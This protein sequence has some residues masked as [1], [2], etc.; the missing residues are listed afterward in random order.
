MTGL[1]TS[2]HAYEYTL[3]GYYDGRNDTPI[4]GM[5][6]ENYAIMNCSVQLIELRQVLWS[7]AV[8][9]VSSCVDQPFMCRNGSDAILPQSNF[10]KC[11][12]LA[13]LGG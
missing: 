5:L 2:N 4:D 7:P 1:A 12:R 11:Q 6:Y 9:T 3:R 13:V 8:D 10:M